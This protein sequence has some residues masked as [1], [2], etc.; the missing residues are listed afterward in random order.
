MTDFTPPALETLLPFFATK[1]EA[2]RYRKQICQYLAELKHDADEIAA[3]TARIRAMF[4]QRVPSNLGDDFLAR[5][6]YVTAGGTAVK[7]NRR[8]E[9]K[10]QAK[11]KAA[12]YA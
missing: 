1:A 11:N 12:I 10:R 8:R 9:L 7:R 6:H 3:E 2:K 4:P 5:Y